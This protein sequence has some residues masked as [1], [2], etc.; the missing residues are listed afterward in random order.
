V[1]NRAL[2]PGEIQEL[3]ADPFCM[4]RPRQRLALFV[5]ATS[6]GA[7]AGVFLDW[8]APDSADLSHYNIYRG[9]PV[10]LMAAVHDTSVDNSWSEAVPAGHYEYLVRAED[11]AGNEEANLSQ[12]VAVDIDG[13]VQVLRPN[14]P[15]ILGGEA[16]AG[17]EV[18]LQLRY[19][20]TGEA[21]VATVIHLY[22]DG[23]TT[24]YL[25]N[26]T[27][28]TGW[29]G[30]DAN[31]PPNTLAMDDE[32]QLSG[33]QLN[34]ISADDDNSVD[35]DPGGA[36]IA[37]HH[38][39]YKITEAE[40]TVTDITLTSKGYGYHVTA[41]TYAFY[42]Y[43]WNFDS[44][45]W[46]LLDSHTTGSKDTATGSITSN[47]PNYIDGDGYVH[48]LIMNAGTG[49]I[50][51]ALYDYYNEMIISYSGVD[52]GSSVGSVAL[53]TGSTF[54]F[55]EVESSGL[56]GGQTYLCGVRA[57][58]AGAVQDENTNTTSVLT[59]STAPGAPSVSLA[60]T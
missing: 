22:T 3:A 34:T 39:R 58:T 35:T 21:A 57:Q 32:T 12:M 27:N 11:A 45:T 54:Q 46:E 20:R 23:A 13:G 18:K 6:V 14:T 30:Y 26:S 53:A 50:V 7:A 16:I 52:W 25:P 24:T 15:E 2:S 56:T 17:G 41:A 60:V 1:W 47:W 19:D 36:K 59:D 9:D 5:G 29:Y 33:A 43:I 51:N 28:C 44:T 10:D 37:G 55:V 8:T 31:R 38:I 4:I 40:G 42:L 48:A 49:D